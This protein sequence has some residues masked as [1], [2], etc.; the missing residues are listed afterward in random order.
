LEYGAGQKGGGVLGAGE[1]KVLH[2]AAKT[3]LTNPQLLRKSLI[4]DQKWY[5][6]KYIKKKNMKHTVHHENR[7]IFY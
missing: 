4:T 1:V 3:Q 6:P 5:V 2:L 7:R